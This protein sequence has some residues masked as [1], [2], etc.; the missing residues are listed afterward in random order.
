MIVGIGVDLMKRQRITTFGDDYDDAFF[1]RTFTEAERAEAARATDRAD[2]YAGRFCAKEAVIKALAG[3]AP[4]ARFCDIETLSDVDG[5]PHTRLL[6]KLADD[7]S[8]SNPK[9]VRIHISISHENDASVAFAIVETE[10]ARPL[11]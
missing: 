7:V 2:Y 9:G 11:K 5:A 6:G 10:T 8:A 3:Q 1:Q 4:D